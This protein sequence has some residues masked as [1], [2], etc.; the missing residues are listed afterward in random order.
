MPGIDLLSH[1]LPP[2]R[3]MLY[4]TYPWLYK[5]YQPPAAPLPFPVL[6]EPLFPPWSPIFSLEFDDSKGP[7]TE[8]YIISSHDNFAILSPLKSEVKIMLWATTQEPDGH[9]CIESL[10]F[11]RVSTG[12]T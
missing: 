7:T 3:T 12:V 1:P 9:F 5:A 8:L 2:H 6:V 4:E 10:F 11:T